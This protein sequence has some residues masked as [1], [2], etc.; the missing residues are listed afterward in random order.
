MLKSLLLVAFVASASA[1]CGTHGGGTAN[2]CTGK[3][4]CTDCGATPCVDVD[5]NCWSCCGTNNMCYPYDCGTTC[6]TK[7]C[8]SVEAS[9]NSVPKKGTEGEQL[10]APA[11]GS[12][13]QK[14]TPIGARTSKAAMLEQP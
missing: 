9:V 4:T 11:M 10:K 8:S 2:D 5:E 12:H 1:M 7:P 13:H 3:Y 6:S 14:A